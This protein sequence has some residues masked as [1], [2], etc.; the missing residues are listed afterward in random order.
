MLDLMNNAKLEARV[1]RHLEFLKAK[2]AKA[3]VVAKVKADNAKALT[4]KGKKDAS[5][6]RGMLVR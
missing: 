5:Q 6:I 1:N 4:P 3:Q 2:D